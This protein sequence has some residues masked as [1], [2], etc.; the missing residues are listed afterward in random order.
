MLIFNRPI[1]G[2]LHQRNGEPININ[3]DDTGYEACQYKYV[4][5]SGSNKDLFSFPIRFT[6]AVQHENGDRGYIESLK[7]LTTATTGGDP[8]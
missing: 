2:L 5:V 7:R 3:N 1:R 4:K 6:V 8:T